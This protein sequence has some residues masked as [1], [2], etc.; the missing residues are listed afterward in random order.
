MTQLIEVFSL[1][2][3]EKRS[4][5]I[6]RVFIKILSRFGNTV[7]SRDNRNLKYIQYGIILAHHS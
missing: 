5:E 3:D 7:K 6:F 2:F 4:G 1:F